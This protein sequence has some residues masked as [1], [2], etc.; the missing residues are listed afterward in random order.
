MFRIPDT[1]L[2]MNA[3][4]AG[5][6]LAGLAM[7]AL[8]A[9]CGGGDKVNPF[10]PSKIIAF[11]DEN[12]A[13]ESST[14]TLSVS[15]D[16]AGN[17]VVTMRG[18]R[19][20]INLLTEY[21]DYCSNDPGVGTSLKDCTHVDLP[22]ATASPLTF[23]TFDSPV[24]VRYSSQFATAR[25][26]VV[27]HLESGHFSTAT[28][29]TVYRTTDLVYDCSPGVTGASGYVGNWVQTLAYGFSSGL[30]FGGTTQCPQDSGNGKS[31]AE[32]GAKVADV[33]AQKNAHRGE[34]G[35]GVLVAILAGQNDIM[36][37][38]D[39]IGANTLTQ[40]AASI[41]LR[42]AGAQLARVI[43]DIITT[44]ARVV[45]LTVPDMGKSPK[46]IRES[47]SA[48][49][50]ELTKAFNEGYQNQGGLVLSVTINGHKIVKVDGFSQ[51]QGIAASYATTGGCQPLDT[52]TMPDGVLVKTVVT[53]P[54]LQ[55]QAVLLNCTSHNL[56]GGASF[57]TF[58]WA[59]DTHLAPIGHAS[60]ANLAIARVQSQL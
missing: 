12:S 16:G 8:V 50:T 5:M 2:S 54:A 49:A 11:G 32:W 9:G 44:G 57:D 3:R 19:Y 7:A 52:A 30:S 36:A 25:P 59:D 55:K 1:A 26:Q 39:E 20:T 41:R 6:A 22:V 43:N 45:Y 27:N 31:Y 29:T 35:N 48:L 42:E 28:G 34:L 40:D 58:L 38:Y 53:D 46:A 17:H 47:K 14:T 13:F 10:H 60:L 37:A 15:G 56:V 23:A 4:R 51:I 33:E 18:A 21:T 24:L